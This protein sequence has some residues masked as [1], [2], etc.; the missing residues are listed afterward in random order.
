MQTLFTPWRFTYI[1]ASSQEA[2]C[3][4]CQ[5][6]GQVDDPECLV[7]HRGDHHLVMLNRYPYTNGHLMIA[8]LGHV[9][10]PLGSSREAVREFWPLVLRSQRVLQRSYR[11][12]GFN[13]GLN[14]GQAAG[15]G[16]PGHFHFHVVPRWE[17]DTNFMSVVGEVRIVP[18]SLDQVWQ[19][20][21]AL[22]AAEEA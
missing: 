16:V 18:E 5:A 4:F 8:P 12:D 2:E 19:K 21:R 17:G 3:F 20:L 15:A 22:F 6:A 10:D 9:G 7:V 1:S 11:P 13:M 14:L